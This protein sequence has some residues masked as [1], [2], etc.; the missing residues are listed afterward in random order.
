MDE[1]ALL[2]RLRFTPDISQEEDMYTAICMELGL[3]ACAETEGEAKDKLQQA[4]ISYC[5]ALK[6]ANLL[7]KA[8]TESQIEWELIPVPIGP[9]AML[10]DL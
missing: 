4:I 8:L 3:A 9:G 7:E 1:N 6:R 2:T 10:I 5:N